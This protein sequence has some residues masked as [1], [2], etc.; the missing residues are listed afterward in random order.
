VHGCGQRQS[1]LLQAATTDEA[2]SKINMYA[3]RYTSSMLSALAVRQQ[4]T[5]S[6][7]IAHSSVVIENALLCSSR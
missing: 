2:R 3:D 7:L 6:V 1:R 5:S 4:G